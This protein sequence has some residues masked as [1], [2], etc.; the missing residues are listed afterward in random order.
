MAKKAVNSPRPKVDS[1]RST[2]GHARTPREVPPATLVGMLSGQLAEQGRI[3]RSLREDAARF[4]RGGGLEGLA[5]SP[6]PIGFPEIVASHAGF[7]ATA[8]LA[9]EHLSVA[10]D[11]RDEIDLDL[12]RLETLVRLVPPDEGEARQAAAD[13]A[14]RS[15]EALAERIDAALRR[16]RLAKRKISGAAAAAKEFG[17]VWEKIEEAE[18]SFKWVSN[19]LRHFRALAAR[20]DWPDALDDLVANLKMAAQMFAEDL[21]HLKE[22]L[23][24]ID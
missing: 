22:A 24:A 15:A 13:A 18:A 3:I 4:R 17:E 10:E 11:E 14:K 8:A 6:I 7:E 5:F 1:R 12:G 23:D 9:G 16:A 21:E 19:S 20:S 2:S